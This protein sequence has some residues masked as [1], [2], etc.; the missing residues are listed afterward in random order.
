MWKFGFKHFLLM[1]MPFIGHYTYTRKKERIAQLKLSLF[2]LFSIQDELKS[3]SHP[4]QLPSPLLINLNHFSLHKSIPL[5]LCT[6]KECNGDFPIKVFPFYIHC[7]MGV[8]YFTP[9]TIMA[10]L[11]KPP[12]DDPDGFPVENRM[13]EEC[14]IQALVPAW[15]VDICKVCAHFYYTSRKILLYFLFSKAA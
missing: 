13:L 2:F 12:P 9:I 4:V 7:K 8:I 5:E 6:P 10:I 1:V 14:L 3:N 15:K 11:F